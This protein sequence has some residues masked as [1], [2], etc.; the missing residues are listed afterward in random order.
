MK[1]T[2]AELNAKIA[3][4]HGWTQSENLVGPRKV[5]VWLHPDGDE[6]IDVPAY[7]SDMNL[8]IELLG[9]MPCH[10]LVKLK[11]KQ[12]GYWLV[13]WTQKVPKGWAKLQ[14]EHRS[15]CLAICLAWLRYKT[16]EVYEVIEDG[17]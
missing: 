12:G 1:I 10:G 6:S 2:E 4:H 5:P 9:R 16:G 8:A 13:R 15:P 11:T 14:A 3:K 7:S 17:E